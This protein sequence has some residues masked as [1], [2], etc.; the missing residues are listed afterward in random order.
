LAL[1]PAALFNDAK[2]WRERAERAGVH[3]NLLTDAE[4]KRTMLEVAGSYERLAARAA[5][6][7]LSAGLPKVSGGTS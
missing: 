2:H 6:G 5:E 3:A 7:E 1:V 4:A